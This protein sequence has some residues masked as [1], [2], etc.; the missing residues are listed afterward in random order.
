MREQVPHSKDIQA[1][2]LFGFGKIVNSPWCVGQVLM[3]GL[4][5]SRHGLCGRKGLFT[6]CIFRLESLNSK[7]KSEFPNNAGFVEDDGICS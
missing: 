5:T 3:Y 1:C 4:I 6:R 7:K 2:R